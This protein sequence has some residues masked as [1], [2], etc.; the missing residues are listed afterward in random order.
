MT[1]I[2]SKNNQRYKMWKKLLTKKGREDQGAFLVEGEHLVQEVLTAKWPVKA[3][4]FAKDYP[5][6]DRWLDRYEASVSRHFILPPPL[7]NALSE[8]KTPQGIAAVVQKR[9]FLSAEKIIRQS[10]LLLLVDRVR[11]PGNLGTILR[12]ADAAGVDAVF[13]GKGTVDPYSGKVMR[14]T[15]GSLFHVPFFEADLLDVTASIQAQGGM[16]I[17][18]QPSAAVDYR[19]LPIFA[20]QCAALIVGNEGAGVHPDLLPKV[21]VNISIPIWGQ[22]ESLNVAVATGIILYHIQSERH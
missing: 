12:T 22:A 14:S 4:I 17:G 9:S 20:D 11:D 1:Y 18:T 5:S 8:T 15:Q 2:Q 16:V 19:R 13:L 3:L 6:V 10:R 7:F 21:D